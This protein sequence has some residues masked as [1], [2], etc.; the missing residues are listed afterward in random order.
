[1]N[2]NKMSIVKGKGEKKPIPRYAGGKEQELTGYPLPKMAWKNVH[3]V[4]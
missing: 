2:P 4:S 1:M 3:G